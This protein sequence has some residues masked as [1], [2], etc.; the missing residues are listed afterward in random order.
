M[1]LM[2]FF[3]NRL[4]VT[5]QPS[6]EHA[7]VRTQASAG[8]QHRRHVLR[9][10]LHQIA[11]PGRQKGRQAHGAEGSLGCLTGCLRCLQSG[12]PSPRKLTRKR[13]NADIWPEAA[14]ADQKCCSRKS[15]TRG[16][17]IRRRRTQVRGRNACSQDGYDSNVCNENRKQ[18]IFRHILFHETQ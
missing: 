15:L 17:A 2:H 13:A 14:Q 4:F 5:A 10:S 8:M 18:R 1:F 16:R 12:L 6:K 7:L 9:A 3:P 11:R